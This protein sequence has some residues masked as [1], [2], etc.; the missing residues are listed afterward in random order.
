MSKVVIP[1]KQKIILE[2]EGVDYPITKPTFGWQIDFEEKMAQPNA[3]STQLLRDFIVQSGLPLEV[4][5]GLDLD[6]LKAIQAVILPAK[7]N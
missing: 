4:V 1:Q 5:N 6:Q 3:K 7:K 2:I